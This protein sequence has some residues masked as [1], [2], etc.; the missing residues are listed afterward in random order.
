M[1]VLGI[2][3]S[4]D[5]TAASI[6]KDGRQ[7]LSN[8]VSTQIDIHK[9]YGGIVPELAARNHIENISLVTKEALNEAKVDINDIDLIAATQGPG[10]VGSLLIGFSFAKALAFSNQI[11]FVGTNH[12]LG[13]IYSIFLND[14]NIEMPFISLLVSG[15]HTSLFYVSS[16]D[17]YELIGQTMDDAAGEA[18]DKVAKMLG[19]GYPGGIIIDELS[20]KSKEGKEIFFTRPYPKSFDFSFSGLKTSVLRYIEQNRDYKN[21]IPQI[22][23]G[24]QNAV[25]DVLL[26]KLF[27]L[28]ETKNIKNISIVGGVSAN[29]KLR[30]EAKK[31]SKEKGFNL[32]LPQKSLCGDNAAM[33]GGVASVLHKN[34]PFAL[35]NEDVFSRFKLKKTPNL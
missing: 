3:T 4:C 29:S 6:V 31:I 1:I 7:I 5:E 16:F 12:L 18:F 33:I 32:Y 23:S 19:F 27:K 21:Q 13:H 34:E 25:V 11:P 8:V 22:V 14:E 35:N 26:S 20:K 10:L 24:F 17:K 28:A 30:E 9:K 15:G 2:E